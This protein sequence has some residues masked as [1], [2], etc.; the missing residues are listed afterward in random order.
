MFKE[1]TDNDYGAHNENLSLRLGC[2]ALLFS[3]GVVGDLLVYSLQQ[4]ISRG[5]DEQCWCLVLLRL[6]LILLRCEENWC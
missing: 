1:T 2:A 3:V 6:C 4:Y 5:N